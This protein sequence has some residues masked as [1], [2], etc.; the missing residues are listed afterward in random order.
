MP[1]ILRSSKAAGSEKLFTG[2]PGGVFR[3]QKDSDGGSPER[4]PDGDTASGRYG[5]GIGQND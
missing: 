3:G 1:T 4:K 2:D 5:D